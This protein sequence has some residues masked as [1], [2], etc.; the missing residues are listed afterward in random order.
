MITAVR[1]SEITGDTTTAAT[2]V[3][4]RVEDA[5]ELLEDY[6][7][8]PLAHGERTESLIPD[9]FGRLWPKATPISDGGDY[10]VEG[11]ALVG[12]GPFGLSGFIDPTDSIEVTYSGGWTV[13][14]L[15]SCI[16]RDLAWAT[17]R[18]LHPE[19]VAPLTTIA[20]GATS[21]RLGD[22]ALTWGAGGRPAPQ[23]TD[24]WWSRRTRGYRYAPIHA[25]PMPYRAVL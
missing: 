1:Y 18:L 6:L 11:L 10:T 22:A 13:D 5:V 21:A 7:D 23:D 15:P 4:A 25:G 17:Y 9:R 19:S 20:A 16:E 8:R 24:G 2:A 14:T 12:P 3:S